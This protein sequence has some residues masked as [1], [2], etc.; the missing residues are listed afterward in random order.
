MKKYLITLLL[1]MMIMISLP[2]AVFARA[3]GSSGGGGSSSGGSGGGTSSSQYYS[4]DN[5]YSGSAGY[6]NRHGG[7]GYG[8]Y[9]RRP[10][11]VIIQVLFFGF[12][13]IF[14]LVRNISDQ[15]QQRRQR[16]FNSTNTIPLD[17]STQATF[18]TLFYQVETA[19]STN[20]LTAISNSLTP[21]F[22]RQQQR[23]LN[24]YQRRHKRNILENITIVDARLILPEKTNLKR[25]LVTAQMRDYFVDERQSDAANLHQQEN[26]YIERFT[27]IWELQFDNHQYKV[28]R[29][30][31]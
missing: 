9:G 25:I 29:I 30:K 7:Y 12:A 22:Q 11:S 20:D 14:T 17:D 19:W 31:Q 18:E 2:T 1:V 23:I 13:L 3:G 8:G 15:R 4:N 28:K 5:N 26:T 24:R 27:E 6:Y 16:A 10:L 21:R